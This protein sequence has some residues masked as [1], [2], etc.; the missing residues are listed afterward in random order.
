MARPLGAVKLREIASASITAA[1]LAANMLATV[2]LPLPMPPVRP[3]RQVFGVF[4]IQTRM[5]GWGP[6][7]MT[8]RPA[9]A[10]KGPKGI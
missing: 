6:K 9:K 2:L 8:Q 5:K 10:K 1:P 7:A 4:M 3:I